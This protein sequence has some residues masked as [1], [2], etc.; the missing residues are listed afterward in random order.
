MD[1]ITKWQASRQQLVQD[2]AERIDVGL[3]PYGLAGQLLG[4]RVGRVISRTVV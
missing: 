3:D 1:V 4:R 2:D